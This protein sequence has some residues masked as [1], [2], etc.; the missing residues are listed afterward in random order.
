MSSVTFPTAIG[1]DGSTVTDDDNATTGLRNGGW[2]TR[3]IPCFTNLVNI[4]NYVVTYTAS[5]T[6]FA[7]PPPIGSTTPNTGAFT[8]VTVTGSTAPAN[9]IYLPGTNS[10]GFATNSSE[11]VRIDAS[12]N[13]GIGTSSPN[14]SAAG[15]AL[16]ILGSSTNRANLELGSTTAAASSAFGQISGYNGA[17]LASLVQLF[18]DGATDSGAIKF[19]TKATGGAI[20]ERL[21]LD[22]SGNLGL[23]VTPSGW[24]AG[25][26]AIQLNARSSWASEGSVTDINLN[27]YND[28]I[29]KYIATAF[30]ARYRQQSGQHQ[31]FT[32]PSGTAGNAISFTQAMTLD[33]SGNLGIGTTSPQG[34]IDA[35]GG[36]TG[37]HRSSTSGSNFFSTFSSGTTGDC[38][39]ANVAGTGQN[40]MRFEYGGSTKGTITTNGTTITYGGTSDQRLKN[41][42]IDAPSALDS[43]NAIKV[44]SFDWNSDGSHAD[45]GY[46]AQELLDIV[47][48]AVHVPVNPE[49]LLTVDFGK[50]TPRLVKAIQEL[51]ARL[52]ALEGAK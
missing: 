33:A 49:E 31:W 14:I 34:K 25:W 16:T 48:E 46:I 47:P 27:V 23:G 37:F 43:V 41:N 38:Y 9:G 45:Y 11:R 52:E 50:L 1:G 36:A 39:Y 19:F 32:A 8:R 35:S 42:I 12:G 7:T 30:A 51:T 29:D 20:T 5:T 4:A 22:S 2:R 17:T 6:A 18:G 3:F 15:T 21:R 26:K 40:F 10:L 44:R 13:V 24:V 28:G